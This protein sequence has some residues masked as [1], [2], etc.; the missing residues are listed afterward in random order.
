MFGDLTLAERWPLSIPIGSSTFRSWHMP[1]ALPISGR[2]PGGPY[3]IMPSVS[4]DG[5]MTRTLQ[6][7]AWLILIGIAAATLSPISIRPSLPVDVDL[8]RGLAFC[9]AGFS[10]AL[11][12][13]KKIWLAAVITITGIIG[14]EALQELRPDRHGRVDDALIKVVG[15]SVGLGGGWMSA[16]L[17]G[18][19][20]KSTD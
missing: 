8:E 14:L 13:P 16:K 4:Y 11:A 12:Y 18:R 17:L 7:L 6:I 15:G 5:L 19:R 3:T 9:L 20:I 10:F 1:V 2:L